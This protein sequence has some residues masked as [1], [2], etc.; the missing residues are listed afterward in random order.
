MLLG[1]K[2]RRVIGN[3]LFEARHCVHVFAG[4]IE[5]ERFAPRRIVGGICG[6]LG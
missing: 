1:D 4:V 6:S 2:V 5:L 3:N